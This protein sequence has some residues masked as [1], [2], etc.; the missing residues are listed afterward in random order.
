MNDTFSYTSEDDKCYG[1]TGMAIAVVVYDSEDML[2]S[3]SLDASPEHMLEY[4]DDFSL[5]AIPDCQ[6]KAHGTRF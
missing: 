4:V 6:L 5:P 3:I 2:A 1:A